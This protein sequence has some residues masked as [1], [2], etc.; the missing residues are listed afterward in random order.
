M[1]NSKT[2]FLL[3]FCSI[4]F[5]SAK[6]ADNSHNKNNHRSI[7]ELNFPLDIPEQQIAGI[8]MTHEKHKEQD[9]H[10]AFVPIAKVEEFLNRG[11]KF[12]DERSRELYNQAKNQTSDNDYHLHQTP[13]KDVSPTNPREKQ[14]FKKPNWQF[15]RALHPS[16]L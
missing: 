5:H 8:A 9:L 15:F 16:K 6:S 10:A 3:F 4:F 12:L 2:F 7:F 11:Y 13:L 14:L 1:T